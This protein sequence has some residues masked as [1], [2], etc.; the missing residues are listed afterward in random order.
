MDYQN[1]NETDVGA[2][3]RQI[4]AAG[5]YKGNRYDLMDLSPNR[6]TNLLSPPA[7]QEQHRD[8]TD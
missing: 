1:Y 5:I 2:G 7:P 4:Y 3:G 6:D 8:N